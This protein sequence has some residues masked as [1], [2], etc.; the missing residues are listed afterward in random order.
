M[1][2]I[3]CIFFSVPPLS[4]LNIQI[5][6]PPFMGS[7]ADAEFWYRTVTCPVY[8]NRTVHHALCDALEANR[9]MYNEQISLCIADAIEG[10]PQKT[11]YQLDSRVKEL[12]ASNPF[13]NKSYSTCLREVS[14][15]VRQAVDSSP[16]KDSGNPEDLPS[17][18]KPWEYRSFTYP[19]NQGFE[20]D[21]N[22]LVLKKIGKVKIRNVHVPKD[23]ELRTLTMKLDA[24]CRWYAYFTYRVKKVVRGEIDL[25]NPLFEAY[26]FGLRDIITDTNGNKVHNPKF[27]AKDR[28]TLSNLRH[29]LSECGE[30]TEEWL[31][32]KSKISRT[33]QKN[34]RRRKGLINQISH[35]MTHGHSFVII[36][37][38]SPKEMKENKNTFPSMR[39]QYTDAAWGDLHTK[40]KQK[41]EERDVTIIEVDPKDTSKTCSRCGN[42]KHEFSL[43]EKKYRCEKCGLY[44]DRDI[45]AARNIL[46]K[47]IG[48]DTLRSEW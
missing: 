2:K 27:S 8:A 48:T 29:H 44:L 15:R 17:S 19:F 23:G 10:I 11:K 20:L 4:S 25:E 46:A 42:V 6:N 38:L 26:D 28:T 40:L 18:R 3:I 33:E 36:E 34:R 37:R 41:A 30:G 47:G 14:S 24:K 31:K 5:A 45:N 32:V 21:G 9:L 12:V 39:N 1:S 35:D 7:E 43:S 13:L 22:I 16:W